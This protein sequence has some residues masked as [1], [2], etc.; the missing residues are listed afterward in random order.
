MS[1]KEMT[2]E[3]MQELMAQM[4]EEAREIFQSM[5]LKVSSEAPIRTIKRFLDNF[6]DDCPIDNLIGMLVSKAIVAIAKA[7]KEDMDKI[8]KSG[9]QYYSGSKAAKI[10][11]VQIRMV[12]DGLEKS[13]E[14]HSC[15]DCQ[16]KH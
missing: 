16:I 15:C 2:S 14:N 7:I 1:Y 8:E 4:P 3:K 13:I 6:A 5:L 11:I 12:A 10:A 9:D